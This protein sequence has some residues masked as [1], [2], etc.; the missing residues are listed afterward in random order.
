M[1]YD[2]TETVRL[3]ATQAE[4][5]AAA[6]R[7]SGR[8]KSDL[9]RDVIDQAT[10]AYGDQLVADARG[11]AYV[12]DPCPYEFRHG[13]QFSLVR[14]AYQ[15]YTFGSEM[16][17]EAG[18]RLRRFER[19][20]ADPQV[21]DQAVKFATVTTSN[22]S[23]VVPPGYLALFVAPEQDRPLRNAATM[24]PL[25]GSYPATPFAVPDGL[26]A[27]VVAAG[28]GGRPFT[29]APADRSTATGAVGNHTEG[30]NPTDGTLSFGGAMPAVTPQGKS[31]LFRVT[32]EVL[33]ASNPNVDQVVL[34]HMRE[35]YANQCEQLVY[36]ELNGANGQGGTITAGRV[37]SGAQVSAVAAAALP[38]ELKNALVKYPFVRG[39]RVRSVAVSQQ[40]GL[41]LV[42]LDPSNVWLR[43]VQVDAAP[44]IPD[45]AAGDGDVFA[46]SEGDLWAW[47]SPLLTFRFE[48]KNGPALVD[49]ALFGYFAARLLRP[50]G[51]A[52]VR[53]S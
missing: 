53:V 41:G 10:A 30:T 47:E 27:A 23:Q 42:D 28:A 50:S 9:L 14:D 26:N 18:D 11:A 24:L 6:A 48:E 40:A 51:L 20:Q 45:G 38:G 22:A 7:E 15:V 35:Q 4:Q 2:K 19:W 43:D 34:T 52:A 17:P 29:V 21:R 33:D 3:S 32:R 16:D 37:P 25:Q 49:L 36:A 13:A 8:Q 44:A 46:L 5:L 1:A 31:G 39:R 12:A